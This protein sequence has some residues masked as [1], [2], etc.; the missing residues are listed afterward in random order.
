MLD[1]RHETEALNPEVHHEGS[2]VDVKAILWFT[3][4]FVVFGIVTHVFLYFHFLAMRKMERT[5]E[6]LPVSYVD[7]GQQK[8]PPEPRLQPFPGPD[9]Q[10][11]TLSP[12]EA[13]PPGDM[14]KMRAD[15]DQLLHGYGWA[16]RATGMVR[17]PIDRA[18][19]LAL[20]RGFTVAPTPGQQAPMATPALP[21]QLQPAVPPH[22]G[23]ARSPEPPTP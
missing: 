7:Q 9:P 19:E 16:N 20:E 14:A 17:V 8:L 10:G 2:D 13:L 21:D 22:Q 1:E 6:L 18:K 12:L 5:P 23:T 11:G 4:I 15:E 3:V